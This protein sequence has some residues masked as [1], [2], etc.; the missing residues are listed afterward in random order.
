MKIKRTILIG[1]FCSIAWFCKSPFDTDATSDSVFTVTAEFDKTH[2]IVDSLTVNLSW[3]EITLENF[4]EIKITR[5][6]NNR[7]P[8]SYP[9]GVTENGWITIAVLDNEFVTS[10]VD[11]VYDDETFFYRIDYYNTDNNYRRSETTITIRPTTKLIVPDDYTDVKTAVESYIIDAG[12]SVLLMRGEY[13]SFAFSFLGK[14]VHL[15]GADGAR[16]T[17]LTWRPTLTE[18][19]K[20]I[21]DSAFIRM[22]GGTI[23]GLTIKGGYAYYGG[24]V[25]ASGNSIIQNCIITENK[26]GILSNGGLGGGLYL[27][28]NSNISNSIISSN[29]ADELGNGIYIAQNASLVKIT[30]CTFSDNNLFNNSQNVFIENTIID[31]VYTGIDLQS[32]YLPSVMYSYAGTYWAIQDT[33]N[34]T[35]QLL[36]G[37]YFHLLPGSI[38]IDSGN[39]NLSFNDIDGTRNDLGAYGG[40]LGD[41]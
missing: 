26:A 2:R 28:G 12:D 23:K 8:N 41:W 39:P 10:Y 13:S 40:P 22:T 5:L 15:I 34:I 20:M 24:G 3:S 29:Y 21:H 36:F 17:L 18:S 25:Y 19:E 6:N 31:N 33:T 35:G 38:C 16:Q 4:K 14:N 7:D 11:T 9:T 27:T 1:M 37:D 30:N 32:T